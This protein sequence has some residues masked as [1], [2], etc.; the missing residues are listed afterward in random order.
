MW[1]NG[2]E[3]GDLSVKNIMYRKRETGQVVGVLNDWDLATRRGG[4]RREVLGGGTHR[5][6]TTPFAALRLFDKPIREPYRLY[7]YDLESAAWLLPYATLDPNHPDNQALLLG[8]HDRDHTVAT[9]TSFLVNGEKYKPRQGFEDLYLFALRFM[10]WFMSEFTG[11]TLP[12]DPGPK[13]LYQPLRF[14]QR[15]LSEVTDR[16]LRSRTINDRAL[17]TSA[18]EVKPHFKSER[19]KST[20]NDDEIYHKVLEQAIRGTKT[21][22]YIR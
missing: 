8:W 6:G 19:F 12:H 11:A 3:H 18:V 14:M 20:H 10:R 21:E 2:F 17:L 15:L 16:L 1:T 7:V 22:A 5:T 13:F 9:R 4:T